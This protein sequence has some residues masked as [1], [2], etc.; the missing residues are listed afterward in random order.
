MRKKVSSHRAKNQKDLSQ[1][2]LDINQKLASVVQELEEIKGE[3]EIAPPSCW[4]VRNKRQRKGRVLLVLQMD[5]KRSDFHQSKT[6]K[7]RPSKYIGKAGSEDYLK[8]V[9]SGQRRGKI[10]ANKRIINILSQG[11]EDLVEEATKGQ[12]D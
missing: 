9:S 7:M 2:I 6:N 3:G 5:G 1:R 4:I 10:E 12:K 11:L 8:A